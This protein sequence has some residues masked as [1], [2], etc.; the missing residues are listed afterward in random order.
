MLLPSLSMVFDGSGPLVKR[1]DGFDGSL[2]SNMSQRWKKRG[3]VKKLP[4]PACWGFLHNC[5]HH[6]HH[7]IDILDLI[8]YML[9]SIIDLICFPCLCFGWGGHGFAT[10]C[11][12]A[13]VRSSDLKLINIK[14]NNLM[15]WSF[16]PN[17]QGRHCNC[18][19]CCWLHFCDKYQRKQQGII[20]GRQNHNHLHDSFQ[21]PHRYKEGNCEQL[22]GQNV[23]QR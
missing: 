18:C 19:C 7:H 8:S 20:L 2:W 16:F 4:N 3:L 17:N 15:A 21:G 23:R 6:H 5:L 12:S 1:C 14:I 10:S 13:P 9:P 11:L 22:L